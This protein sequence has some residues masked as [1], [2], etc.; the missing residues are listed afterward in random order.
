MWLQS[1]L[2]LEV[3]ELYQ[4]DTAKHNLKEHSEKQNIHFLKYNQIS[5]P[6]CIYK[7][8]RQIKRQLHLNQFK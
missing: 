5:L 6:K 7:Q 8:Q 1:G 4:I 3:Q 2:N